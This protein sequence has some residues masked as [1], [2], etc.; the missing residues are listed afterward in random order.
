MSEVVS[1]E[2][3]VHRAMELGYLGIFWEPNKIPSN[4]ARPGSPFAS[5]VGVAQVQTNQ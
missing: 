2:A 4:R 1:T 5:L 3:V